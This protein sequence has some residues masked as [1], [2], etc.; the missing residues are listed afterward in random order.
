MSRFR[1]RTVTPAAASAVPEI[2]LC[3]EVRRPLSVPRVGRRA[4]CHRARSK[5]PAS[6]A[7]S[8]A[9]NRRTST[10]RGGP[11]LRTPPS[12]DGVPQAPAPTTDR[13]SAGFSAASRERTR[14]PR[15]ATSLAGR[16]P[17]PRGGSRPAPTPSGSALRP[18]RQRLAGSLLRPPLRPRAMRRDTRFPL[19]PA[20]RRATL[21][22]RAPAGRSST[23]LLLDPA[24]R[25]HPT[26]H[27]RDP[28]RRPRPVTL[29]AAEA[30]TADVTVL[31]ARA[32]RRLARAAETITLQP[33]PALDESRSRSFK[34][35]QPRKPHV[36]R[37]RAAKCAIARDSPQ[38]RRRRRGS[39][40]F[41]CL[42][43][44]GAKD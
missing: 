14:A 3:P 20:S 11:R 29:T 36:G 15:A 42:T 6:R 23:R 24:R 43:V 41:A 4:A 13:M 8:L 12:R 22:P 21:L 9:A 37:V 26:A 7:N 31:L 38:H 1:R 2:R 32:S 34:R 30:N 27:R 39:P 5:L 18:S 25:R 40:G 28:R 35:D 17:R 44:T 19:G 16:R 33:T 10:G